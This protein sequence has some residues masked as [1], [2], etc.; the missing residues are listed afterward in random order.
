MCW[1]LVNHSIRPIGGSLDGIDTW[2]CAKRW[3][4]STTLRTFAAQHR[5]SSSTLTSSNDS[6]DE[7]AWT[8]ATMSMRPWSS[9]TSSINAAGT[10]GS[11]RSWRPTSNGSGSSGCSPHGISTSC[12]DHPVATTVAPWS[13]SRCAMPTA[14]PVGRDTPVTSATRPSSRRRSGGFGAMPEVRHTRPIRAMSEPPGSRQLA[15]RWGESGRCDERTAR[16]PAFRSSQ[17]GG[18][19][20]VGRVS[21]R[22]AGARPR[23]RG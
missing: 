22:C 23:S 1:P 20:S 10:A 14:I 8:A 5:S 16:I 11:S 2:R 15:H 19:G 9:T 7:R 6:C 3:A 12:G 13:C 18:A 17:W 4:S 21:V